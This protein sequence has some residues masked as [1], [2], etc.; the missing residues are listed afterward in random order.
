[1]VVV[2]ARSCTTSPVAS[3]SVSPLATPW[4]D[5][6]APAV[7]ATAPDA[8]SSRVEPAWGAALNPV[9]VV[10]DVTVTRLPS[11]D[12]H[13]F[14]VAALAIVPPSSSLMPDD[15]LPPRVAVGPV[16]PLTLMFQSV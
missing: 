12:V 16:L 9:M 1:M 2:M 11:V 10:P 15:A 5:T 4:I 13:G 3:V 7:M 6:F 14:S 8:T